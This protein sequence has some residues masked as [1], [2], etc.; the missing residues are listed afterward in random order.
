[1]KDFLLRFLIGGTVVSIFATLGDLFKPKS[2]AGL[3]GAAPAVAL[4][5]LSLTVAAQG[6]AYAATE[7][8]SMIAGSIAFFLYASFV[9]WFLM[10]HRQK[11]LLVA[12]A[13]I[14]VWFA[15]AFGLWQVWLR[16][17]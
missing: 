17:P 12:L 9:S 6:T 13:T 4:A 5:T 2:F 1:M 8:R 3:F 10:R 15:S 11:V 16:Q 7:S 14:P